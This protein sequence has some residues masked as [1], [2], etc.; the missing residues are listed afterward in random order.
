MAPV[1]SIKNVT[2]RYKK[3]VALDGISL[4]QTSEGALN[5]M[6]SILQRVRELAVQ[7]KNGTLSAGNAAAVQSEVYQLASEIER[8]G[9]SAEFQ[10]AAGGVL[11]VI[12]KAGTNQYRGDAGKITGWKRISAEEASKVFVQGL[13]M[14]DLGLIESVMA[15]PEAGCASRF[16]S[17]PFSR[18]VA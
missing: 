2:H 16:C 17:E 1:V 8:L 7:Y 18:V 4:V 3:V 13:V 12:T 15:T 11:N 9:A 14:G 5:E 6:H 10:G